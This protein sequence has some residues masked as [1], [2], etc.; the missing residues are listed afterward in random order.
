[1]QVRGI[2]T[3]SV[4]VLIH[5]EQAFDDFRH[6]TDLVRLYVAQSVESLD[7][8]SVTKRNSVLSKGVSDYIDKTVPT[9]VRIFNTHKA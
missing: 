5:Q 9:T 1:M 6:L 4:Y 7:D 3:R 2:R 8:D